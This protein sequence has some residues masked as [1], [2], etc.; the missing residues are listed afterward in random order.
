MTAVSVVLIVHNDAER[1]PRAL[2]SLRRQT[3][4][5]LEIIV[6]DDA[7]TDAT[8]SVIAAAI[9]EDP[10]IRTIRLPE[11][12]GGCSAP[13][14][15]GLRAALGNWVMFCD[16]D[17]EY[18]RHAAKN[19]LLAVEAADADLGCGVVERV[20][21]RTGRAVRW[22]A[23]LHAPAVLDGIMARPELIAD[24]VSVNKIYRREWLLAQGIAFPEGLLYEDQLFTM[25][26][27][28]EAA[29]I[30]VIDRTVYRWYVER[31]ADE[32]SITQRRHEVRN[33]RSRVEV[34]RRID[35]YLVGRGLTELERVKRRK[36][37]AHD[38]YL[39]LASMLD[40]DDDQ[41]MAVIDE[42]HPYVASLDLAPA[43]TLRPGLRVALLHLLL[44][45][46]EG[47]RS[48][49]RIITWS[50]T[51]DMTIV[52]EGDRDLWGCEHLVH[53]P[54]SG[55][56]MRWWLDVTAYRIRHAGDAR[57]RW[58]HRVDELTLAARTLTV[59]GT[60]V[61][62]FGRLDAV[63]SASV[64]LVRDERVVAQVPAQLAAA[65]DGVWR[66][67]AH[68][69][70][71]AVGQID[72][73]EGG[74]VALRLEFDDAVNLGTVRSAG[75][76]TQVGSGI[77][78]AHGLRIRS[79][80]YG[81]VRWEAGRFTQGAKATA[82]L[83]RIIRRVVR[84][85]HRALLGLTWRVALRMPRAHAVVR[86]PGP[87]AWAL[88]E[89]WRE[90][91]GAPAIHD[92]AALPRHSLRRAWI[93]GRARW[94]VGGDDTF[95]TPPAHTEL[96]VV[97]PSPIVRI[98]RT[99]PDWDITP[100]ASRV[101]KPARVRHWSRV[102]TS[103]AQAAA[104]M[105][106]WS[107]YAGPVL[108]AAPVAERARRLRDARIAHGDPRAVVLYAPSGGIDLDL[109]GLIDALGD[110]VQVIVHRDDGVR[111]HIPS[112]LRTSVTDASD[113]ADVAAL[114]AGADLLVTDTSPLLW[115]A[116]HLDLPVIVHAPH[117]DA[118]TARTGTTIDLRAEGPGPITSDS[119]AL[120]DAVRA[121][122]DRGC[123]PDPAFDAR[124]AVLRARAAADG[125]VAGVL[126]ALH[127]PPVHRERG[128]R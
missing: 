29:R 81:M 109:T 37:L 123:R 53:D 35:A 7:S 91:A 19:L 44:R 126:D 110:R 25:Q 24:T 14:N 114:L 118:V 121:T 17:D 125:T 36:F 87:Q 76:R 16:S 63:R 102:V 52:Q 22:R 103:N 90:R 1:L 93:L 116:V 82:A 18:E 104:G 106:E 117:L 39:Y 58:C 27:F 120:I 4:R 105:R 51:V 95:T 107:G 112:V 77:D 80:D 101:P 89:A 38:L 99:S 113:V 48:A 68:G 70:L 73:G 45:D 100:A 8:P 92:L 3:L 41:A 124:I 119:A 26:A 6:V 94:W 69:R 46:L 40:M 86:G 33:A 64:V 62:A 54:V 43:A 79:G 74:T 34:N 15:A 127:G 108:L 75:I 20:D 55:F 50:A 56:D 84:P 97:P 32:L 96:I 30:A 12:S 31:T 49:M 23:D 67:S 47:I 9:A 98:G 128:G 61:N 71:K 60:T 65:G 88:V 59:H 13:R 11:N 111:T 78:R 57:A 72:D 28:A 83:G 122:V 42:L 66:W 2:R 21:I 10:R 115:D 5:D 85:V